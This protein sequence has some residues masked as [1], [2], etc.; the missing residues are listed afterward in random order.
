[1][2]LATLQEGRR[3]FPEILLRAF[4]CDDPLERLG[5]GVLTPKRTPSGPTEVYPCRVVRFRSE[6]LLGY[7]SDSPHD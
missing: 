6:V 2:L 4:S 5:G 1:M 3:L 7:T